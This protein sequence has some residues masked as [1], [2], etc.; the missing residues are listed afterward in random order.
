[1]RVD[2]SGA[3][4]NIENSVMIVVSTRDRVPAVIGGGNL[5]RIDWIDATLGAGAEVHGRMCLEK[6]SAFTTDPRPIIAGLNIC[7]YVFIETM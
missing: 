1:M 4:R 5:W 6:Y 3:L 7:S 2:I